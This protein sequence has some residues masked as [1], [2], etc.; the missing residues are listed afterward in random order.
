MGHI[1]SVNRSFWVVILG[2]ARLKWEVI[3]PNKNNSLVDCGGEQQ[4]QER[5]AAAR[6]ADCL[7]DGTTERRQLFSRG[8][9]AVSFYYLAIVPV[10]ALQQRLWWLFYSLHAHTGSSDWCLGSG[11]YWSSAMV[12]SSTWSG[13][14]KTRQWKFSWKIYWLVPRVRWLFSSIR[15]MQ[16]VFVI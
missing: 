7:M 6:T 5:E 1:L 2:R 12:S 10:R 3:H 13:P 11:M 4:Q 9:K 15:Y 8:W 16:R 14:W